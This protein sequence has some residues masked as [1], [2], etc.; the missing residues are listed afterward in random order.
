MKLIQ[1]NYVNDTLTSELVEIYN[2]A[3][4]ARKEMAH[5]RSSL[6]AQGWNMYIVSSE[7][8]MAEMNE[9][10]ITLILE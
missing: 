3:V 4:F 6:K 2:K 9:K 7:R 10:R 5:R 1:R 8:A